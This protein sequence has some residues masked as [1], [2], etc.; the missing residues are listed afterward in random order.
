MAVSLDELN[1]LAELTKQRDNRLSKDEL[2]GKQY[3]GAHRLEHIGLAVPP[4][5]R[6]FEMI[7]N[8]NRV[9]VDSVEQRQRVKS[10]I[11]SK[12]IRVYRLSI[13]LPNSLQE[14]ILCRRR[15]RLKPGTL[16]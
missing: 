6:R 15:F 4:E 3:E 7:A 14:S 1:L 2:L 8:W 9:C 11:L 12:S 13:R 10:F 5:L 16:W